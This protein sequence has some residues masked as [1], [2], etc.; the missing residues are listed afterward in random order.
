ML[1][2]LLRVANNKVVCLLLNE[3]NLSLDFFF[4]ELLSKGD[5][6]RGRKKNKGREIEKEKSWKKG[7][8]EEK[9]HD[10]RNNS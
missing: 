3:D 8:P 7:E 9:E 5:F 1:S 10:E 6:L 4:E 2:G